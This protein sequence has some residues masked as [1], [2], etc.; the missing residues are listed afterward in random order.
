MAGIVAVEQRFAELEFALAAGNQLQEADRQ[1][2]F[3]RNGAL[4][5]LEAA[6]PEDNENSVLRLL[7]CIVYFCIILQ[8]QVEETYHEKIP[9]DSYTI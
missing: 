1:F 4:D 5:F 2:L 7:N 3:H 8:S 9:T 6:V